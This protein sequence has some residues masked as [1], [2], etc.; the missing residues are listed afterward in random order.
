MIAV[1]L[2]FKA[3]IAAIVVGQLFIS[4]PMTLHGYI[5][6][7]LH[8]P[9]PVLARSSFGFYL[10]YFAIVSRVV[11]ACFWFG[12]QTTTGGNCVREMIKAIWPSF[13][14]FPNHLPA[15]SGATSQSML[16]YFIYW[17]IQFPF[18]LV[19]PSKIRY[20]FILK[21]ILTPACG[22]S[23]MAWA[24]HKTG[25]GPIFSNPATLT[26]SAAAWQWLTGLNSVLGQWSTLAINIGDFTRYARSPREQY[27]QPFVIPLAFTFIA[28]MGIS[29]TSASKIIYG[30]YHWDPLQII[31][32][33]GN[34]P[35]ERAARFWCA[36]SFT[37]ATL[38]TNIAANS[39]SAGND[40]N[41]LLP[42]YLNI[43]RGSILCAFIGGWVLVPWY[44]LASA[45]RFLGFAGGYTVFL[46]PIAGVMTSDFYLVKKRKVSVPAMYRPKSIYSYWHGINW[47]ALAA[48]LVGC[49]PCFPGFLHNI[50]PAIGNRNVKYM[51][52]ISW[53]YGYFTTA[54][55]Y[56]VLSKLFPDTRSLLDSMIYEDDDDNL[57]D[58][59]SIEGVGSDGAP[60]KRDESTP[61]GIEAGF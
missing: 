46:A 59:E 36:F 10:S 43:R 15:S 38:G 53:L 25:G 1:G 31:A 27:V 56:W 51:F 16:C 5:G 11:L 17:A 40:F 20:L 33:W 7:K 28:F 14:S 23:L 18:L 37:L 35:G 12:I 42:R 32:L 47:R 52:S 19:H 29:V 26:G 34:S 24:F 4:I 22:I 55:V 60:E 48:M 6:A 57:Q 3:S 2:G 41:A 58:H 9:F 50:N 49:I 45:P 39:I 54:A 21:S 44:I 13:A 8:I 61:K 30:E